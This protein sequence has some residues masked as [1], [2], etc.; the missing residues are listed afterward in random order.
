MKPVVLLV[1]EGWAQGCV[2]ERS[3]AG[4]CSRVRAPG[5]GLCPSCEGYGCS[6]GVAE[7]RALA[8]ELQSGGQ[9]CGCFHG[10]L[11]ASLC[12]RPLWE[13]GVL[14]WGAL[15][16]VWVNSEGLSEGVPCVL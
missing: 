11:G 6:P 16:W 3:G 7:Q 9:G 8:G 15:L 5:A 12:A 14:A 13:G 10:P 1:A 4:H 2:S